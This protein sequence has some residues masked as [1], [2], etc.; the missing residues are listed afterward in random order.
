MGVLALPGASSEMSP[1]QEVQGP[2]PVGQQP[3]CGERCACSELREPRAGVAGGSRAPPALEVQ[4]EVGSRR[5]SFRAAFCQAPMP[6][7][8]TLRTVQGICS[9]AVRSPSQLAMQN[10]SES[11]AR[12]ERQPCLLIRWAISC[13]VALHRVQQSGTPVTQVHHIAVNQQIQMCDMV[14]RCAI[15]SP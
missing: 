14:S 13:G 2:T 5:L 4:A 15:P 7:L 10:S 6:L 11:N 1:V 9:Y 12:M 3:G 8:A